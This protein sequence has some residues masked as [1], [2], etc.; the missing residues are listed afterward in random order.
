MGW[1]ARSLPA[2]PATS[3][4]HLKLQLVSHLEASFSIHTQVSPPLFC[5]EHML[6]KL[7]LRFH[8]WNLLPSFLKNYWLGAE[9]GDYL[10][11]TLGEIWATAVCVDASRFIEI[12]GF[13]SRVTPSQRFGLELHGR[14]LAWGLGFNSQPWNERGGGG[15][16]RRGGKEERRKEMKRI[17]GSSWGNVP[18]SWS[19]LP[20]LWRVLSHSEDLRSESTVSWAGLCQPKLGFLTPN[21]QS[22]VWYSF[23]SKTSRY[24]RHPMDPSRL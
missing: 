6:L 8:N 16:E 17:P 7:V 5:W 18:I 20:W 9:C 2:V 1:G 11:V 21:A 23:R 14:S 12:R 24:A 10:V 13:P 22:Y 3:C 19:L 4:F 15:R